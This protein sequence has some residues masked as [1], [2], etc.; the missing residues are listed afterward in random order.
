MMNAYLHHIGFSKGIQ[1]KRQSSSRCHGREKH[2]R[3]KL[4]ENKILRRFNMKHLKYNRIA[5]YHFILSSTSL[6]VNIFSQIF[7]CFKNLLFSFG[8][9]WWRSG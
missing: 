3:N 7:R 4:T 8:L 2:Q 5:L 6:K 9:P 1:S